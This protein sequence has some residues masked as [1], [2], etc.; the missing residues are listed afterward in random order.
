MSGHSDP[1]WMDYECA[2]NVNLLAPYVLLTISIILTGADHPV[3]EAER[4]K[5]LTMIE[6]SAVQQQVGMR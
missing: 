2:P 6:V 4:S 1:F 3:T 5:M